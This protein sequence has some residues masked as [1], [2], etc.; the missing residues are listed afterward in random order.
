MNS[1][2]RRAPPIF[3]A[4]SLPTPSKPRICSKIVSSNR[5]SNGLFKR[6]VSTRVSTRLSRCNGVVQVRSDFDVSGEPVES[7]NLYTSLDNE[8]VSFRI[9][10]VPSGSSVSAVKTAVRS[11]E[12][13]DLLIIA[14]DGAEVSTSEI[15]RSRGTSPLS[16]NVEGNNSKEEPTSVLYVHEKLGLQKPFEV[17]QGENLATGPDV[18]GIRITGLNTRLKDFDIRHIRRIS[19]DLPFKFL[20]KSPS[21]PSK[22]VLSPPSDTPEVEEFN[23]SK[24]VPEERAEKSLGAEIREISA[25]A[26]PALG[27]VIADPLMSLIDT[28]CVGQ[29]CS[30]ELAALGPNTAIFNLVFQVFAFIGVATTNVIA[31]KLPSSPGLSEEEREARKLETGKLMSNAFTLAMVSGVV[32]CIIMETMPKALLATMGASPEMMAPALTYL[33]IRALASPAVM[34]MCA[35]QVQNTLTLM[36]RNV[37]SPHVRFLFF[38]SH[39]RGCAQV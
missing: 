38:S 5:C 21:T 23:V 19:K 35:A 27:S 32:C 30:L 18:D 2:A 11:T 26:G 13:D 25:L 29:Q 39:A 24:P 1:T 22:D 7:P 6:T 10:E 3:S 31:S 14:P 4:L 20:E 15:K 28:A 9:Q 33:K 16:D 34:V 17:E 12:P 8:E 37:H 36:T